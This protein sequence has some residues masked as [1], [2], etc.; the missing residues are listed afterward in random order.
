MWRWQLCRVDPHYS[1][2]FWLVSV[3]YGKFRRGPT[4]LATVGVFEGW[5]KRCRDLGW[6]VGV[7]L[8]SAFTLPA[9]FRLFSCCR[10]RC[11]VG[12]EIGLPTFSSVECVIYSSGGK[13]HGMLFA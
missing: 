9:L 4:L 10:L 6:E 8:F 3:L 5:A 1:W 11:N 13:L 2:R 12:I 7:E